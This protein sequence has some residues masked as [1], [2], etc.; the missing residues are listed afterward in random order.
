MAHEKS[1]QTKNW[2]LA[3]RKTLNMS[4]S[5]EKIFFELI[6][7][8]YHRHPLLGETLTIPEL[9]QGAILEI[10]SFLDQAGDN[11]LLQYMICNW[12]CHDSFVLGG[13][14][15]DTSIALTKT[16]MYVEAHWSMIK[17]GILQN[18]NRPGVD[19]VVFVIERKL[20]RKIKCDM[21]LLLRG[22]EKPNW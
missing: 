7:I 20:L 21:D 4:D 16:T 3:E 1:N 2:K 13:R 5:R 6:D 11:E 12:Y 9:E 15:N 19:I 22:R 18:Y 8:N 14:M 17:R 10:Q